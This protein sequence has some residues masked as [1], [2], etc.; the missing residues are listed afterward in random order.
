MRRRQ[1][2]VEGSAAPA[3]LLRFSP[4]EWLTEADRSA[5]GNWDDLAVRAC[6]RWLDARFAWKAERGIGRHIDLAAAERRG[7]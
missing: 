1:A 7:T 6:R 4:S 2:R 5:R 3:A